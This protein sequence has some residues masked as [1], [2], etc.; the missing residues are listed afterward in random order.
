MTE[1]R[2]R[3][4]PM[5]FEVREDSPAALAAYASVP[6]AFEVRERLVLSA[7]KAWCPGHELLAEPV[8]APYVKDYDATPSEAP[9]S[10]ST[11]FDLTR[12]GL[13]AAWA[14]PQRVGGA[15]IVHGASDVAMLE[16]RADLAVLWDLRV[17]PTWRGRGVGAALFAA[18]EAW[19]MSRGAAWLKVETQDVN[20]SA[21]RFYARQ[22]CTLGAVHPR[23]YPTLP[24][25]VQLLWYKPLVQRAHS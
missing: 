10:W 12:W 3:T 21:C 7:L 11:H 17:A 2:L 24:D 23:A 5:P 25:E 9:T 6:I 13:F 14:G 8:Q 19:A 15:A 1:G 18:A 4:I 22:G 16:G 20:V